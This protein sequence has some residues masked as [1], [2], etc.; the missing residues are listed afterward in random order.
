[1]KLPTTRDASTLEW[2]WQAPRG[3]GLVLPLSK[4][5]IE[6]IKS[7]A[8]LTPPSHSLEKGGDRARAHEGAQVSLK[9]AG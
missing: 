1:M 5:E 3:D 4:G 6:G 9:Q 7:S 2:Y 8:M